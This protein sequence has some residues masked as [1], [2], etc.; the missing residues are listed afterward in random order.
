[1]NFVEYNISSF[2][3]YIRI[4]PY[5]IT[6]ICIF[7]VTTTIQVG[8]TIRQCCTWSE[9]MYLMAPVEFLCIFKVIQLY[10]N[11]CRAYNKTLLQWYWTVAPDGTRR[12]SSRAT[13]YTFRLYQNVCQFLPGQGQFDNGEIHR[14]QIS[15][16]FVWR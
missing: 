8:S 14:T 10:E 9:Q 16:V 13:R 15:P 7:K 3:I 2:K 1:M 4:L 11:T 6:F 5:T 12:S